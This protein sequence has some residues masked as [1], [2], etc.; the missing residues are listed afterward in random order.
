MSENLI[1]PPQKKPRVKDYQR[2]FGMLIGSGTVKD[3]IILIL[4]IACIFLYNLKPKDRYFAVDDQN[5]VKELIDMGSPNVTDNGVKKWLADAMMESYDFN[6]K[7]MTQRM[8]KTCDE[9][10]T[11]K[12]CQEYQLAHEK[13]G[14]LKRIRKEN[15]IVSSVPKGVP[16]VLKSEYDSKRE[17]YH[18]IVQI[19]MLITYTGSQDTP[20][21]VLFQVDVVRS[22]VYSHKSGLAIDSHIYKRLS[23]E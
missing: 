23:Q 8:T 20:T 2:W 13:I 5:R 4:V 18:W 15:L 16:I 14:N 6:F 21:E 22:S 10:Y 7:N 12:G 1:K 19:P 11:K 9:Y 17:V 3:V